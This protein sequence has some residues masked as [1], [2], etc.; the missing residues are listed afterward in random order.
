MRALQKIKLIVKWDNFDKNHASSSKYIHI[1]MF[2][3]LNMVV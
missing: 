2:C 1:I 3:V